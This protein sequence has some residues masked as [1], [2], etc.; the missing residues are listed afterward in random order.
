MTSLRI[1][2]PRSYVGAVEAIPRIVEL[3]ERL[4]ET[5][6]VYDVEGDLYFSVGADPRFGQVANL[7]VPEML[8]VFAERGG[9][10]ER[11]GKKDPLDCLLWRLERP[12]E[13]A[14]PSPFG[15][16]RPGWHI[17]CTAIAL[18]HLGAPI[19]VQGGGSDL[20]FP[21]HEMCAAEAHVLTNG[22]AFAGAYVHAGLL[23]YAG[24]KM[25]KS[26]GNLVFVSK[27]RRSGVDPMAI[28]LALMADHYRSDR[29]WTDELLDA[30]TDRLRMWR[31]AA[32]EPFGPNATPLLVTVRAALANDLDTPMA[33]RAM[34]SWAAAALGG[35]C[36]NN[37]SPELFRHI[38]DALLGIDLD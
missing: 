11:P 20:A 33:L 5:G 31:D 13:P 9:D 16:G 4:K 14:W 15:P 28:R 1:I 7:S 37:D 18:E 6:S 30:A 17:E 23:G 38:A 3:I 32:L 2:P 36:D 10:P 8:E 12:S 34:D 21:H 35:E 25:S 19:D 26:R 29:E 27:L 24:E 22:A